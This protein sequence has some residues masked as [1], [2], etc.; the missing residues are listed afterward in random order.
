M[1]VYFLQ[2]EDSRG[3]G[4][5][6][7]RAPVFSGGQ[8]EKM[9]S[10]IEAV[11]V[12]IAQMAHICGGE[13]DNSTNYGEIRRKHLCKSVEQEDGSRVRADGGPVG[14]EWF[15]G[16]VGGENGRKQSKLHS[17]ESIEL[18]HTSALHVSGDQGAQEPTLD[19][20]QRIERGLT[21][22]FRQEAL[23]RERAMKHHSM[24]S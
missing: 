9:L 21:F 20:S 24:I 19:T 23:R 5:Y 15:A 13:R 7:K 6:W 18:A 14:E 4:R 12:C 10:T 1:L 22:Y 17:A 11:A 3:R 16:S 8:S 2:G